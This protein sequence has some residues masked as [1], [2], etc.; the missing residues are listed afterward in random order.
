LGIA[1]SMLGSASLR[2]MYNCTGPIILWSAPEK[3]PILWSTYYNVRPTSFWSVFFQISFCINIQQPQTFGSLVQE[4]NKLLKVCTL[5]W[6]FTSY[7]IL[8]KWYFFGSSKIKAVILPPSQKECHSRNFRTDYKGGETTSID[9]IYLP[10]HVLIDCCMPTC[11]CRH[12]KLS[13]TSFFLGQILNPET[14]FFWGR[15]E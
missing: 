1:L 13:K 14:S 15:R 9:P 8:T 11:T 4:D 12:V 3:N 7:F 2:P 5:K 10:Y 6:I